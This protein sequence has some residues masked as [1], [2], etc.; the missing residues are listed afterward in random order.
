MAELSKAVFLSYASQDA[1]AAQRLAEALRAGGVEVW[2]DTTELRGGDSWDQKIKKQIRDCALF[3]P[4]ISATTQEREE[5]YFRREWKQAVDRTHDM[6]G[7]AAFLVP[8]VIDD[9]N[10]RDAEV[11][12]EFRSVQWTRLPNG[13]TPPTFVERVRGLLESKG[14]RIDSTRPISTPST[15]PAPPAPLPAAHPSVA[16]KAPRKRVPVLLTAIAAVLAL[17]YIGWQQFKSRQPDVVATVPPVSAI[18]SATAPAAAEQSVAVMPFVNESSDKEQEYF[19]DGLTDTMIDLLSKLPDLRVPARSSS[20]FFKG[21]NEELSAIAAK[22]HVTHVLEGTVRKAGNRLRV[23]AELIR[24]DTGYH[25]WSETYDRDAKDIFKVQDEISA[26]VVAALKL[27]LVAA[28]NNTK[29][30]GTANPEA[31]NEFLIGNHYFLDLPS[32]DNYRRAGAAL[33]KAL[34]LDPAYPDASVKLVLAEAYLADFTGD[35]AGLKRAIAAAERLPLAHPDHGPSYRIRADIR[36]TWQWDWA[37]AQ[38]DYEQAL[39]LDPADAD[40]Y[41]DDALLLQSLGRF[42]E[43][44]V[45]EQKAIALDGLNLGYLASLS[46]VQMS[47]RDYVAAEQTVNRMAEIDPR[48]EVLASGLSALRLLQGRYAESLAEC[49]KIADERT[50]LACV[51]H[52]QHSLGRRTEADQALA[53]LLKTGTGGNLANLGGVYAWFGDA[54]QAFAWFDKA[55]AARESGATQILGDRTLDGL[56]KDPRWPALLK[57]MNLTE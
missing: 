14:A 17:S 40:A 54:D 18:V 33:R 34:A 28:G 45:V 39:A 41:Y 8:I 25:A 13:Q 10:D 42:R 36:S 31:Y 35:A 38:A 16:S 51:V 20:F 26:A 50:R 53:D 46:G 47:Q 48:S 27:K 49:P 56:H 5:G 44:N 3:L 1:D 9:T 55:V 23:S 52:A 37:G 4:I 57:K 7:R 43:A 24:A 6:A 32:A 11:P 29:V 22:L 19:A 15:A 30:R 12:D 2:L 21:K